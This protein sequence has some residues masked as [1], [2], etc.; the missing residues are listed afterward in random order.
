MDNNAAE[1]LE[2][3]MF[4]EDIYDKTS[5]ALGDARKLHKTIKKNLHRLDKDQEK[6]KSRDKKLMIG[7]G[8][9]AAGLGTAAWIAHRRKKKA[10]EEAKKKKEATKEGVMFNEGYDEEFEKIK[11]RMKNHQRNYNRSIDRDAKKHRLA[12]GLGTAA[13][14]ATIGGLVAWQRHVEKKA[15]EEAKKKK[16]QKG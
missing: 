5:K 9:A 15:E 11:K 8:V 3:V 2:R 16:E 7:A 13:G 1:I 6:S 12:V 14:V 4:N 10:E